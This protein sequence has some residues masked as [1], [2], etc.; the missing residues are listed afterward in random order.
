M[1]T[2]DGICWHGCLLPNARDKCS[3]LND[4]FQHAMLSA[5]WFTGD[6]QHWTSCLSSVLMELLH[7]SATGGQFCIR[8]IDQVA[9][10]PGSLDRRGSERE[11]QYNA[12]MI[13]TA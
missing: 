4:I 7:L 5:L 10:L 2:W 8:N 13:Q 11:K 9:K 1:V 6:V 12:C 3:Q